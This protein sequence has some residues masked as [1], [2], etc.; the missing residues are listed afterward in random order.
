MVAKSHGPRR[1]TRSIFRSRERLTV[2][3]YLA[4]FNIG[5]NIV[6]K[7]QSSSDRGQPFRRF[8]GKIGKIIGERGRAY[9]VEIHDGGKAKKIIAK[10]EHLKAI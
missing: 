8:Y 1:R 4:K 7:V 3:K 6:I 9:I 10:P 5:E 2:N